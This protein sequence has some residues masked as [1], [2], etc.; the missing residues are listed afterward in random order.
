MSKKKKK[1]KEKN[2]HN[3]LTGI[4]YNNIFKHTRTN[5]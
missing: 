3:N 2:V 1:L 5:I 4:V